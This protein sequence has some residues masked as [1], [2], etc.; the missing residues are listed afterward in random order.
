MLTFVGLGLYDEHSVT[1][2]GQ[3][4][5]KIADKVF[6]E[7]YTSTLT[8]TTIEAL[9][10]FYDTSISL[11]T[12]ADVEQHPDE[13]LTTASNG[14]TAFLTAGDPMV[15]TT[16][17]DLRLRAHEKN[18]QTRIVH[19]TS[20]QTAASS[21][22]GLQNYRFGKA[23]TLPFPNTYSD[24]EVPKSVIQTITANRNRDLHTLIYLDINAEENQYLDIS[25]AADTL[26]THFPE[27]LGVGIARAGSPDPVVTANTLESLAT[28]TFGEPL[29]LLIIPGALHDLEADALHAF[30]HAPQH[31]LS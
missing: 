23:T 1:L 20:A 24:Q 21:L 7:F 12:R 13:V 9:E 22:T 18:I 17:I 11:A 15:S 3:R 31:L 27:T 28:H 10:Q 4:A 16:H 25:T 8:G 14:K 26:T 29:Q 6:A 2:E 30:A 19:G 5:V